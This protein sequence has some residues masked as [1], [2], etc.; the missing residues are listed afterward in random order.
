MCLK[1][2]CFGCRASANSDTHKGLFRPTRLTNGVNSASGIY[3]RNIEQVLKG[4]PMTVVRVGDIL[5]TGK[6]DQEHLKNFGYIFAEAGRCQFETEVRK[7][8]IFPTISY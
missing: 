4:C 8:Q 1:S 2:N 6:D 5:V 3:Q 7:V